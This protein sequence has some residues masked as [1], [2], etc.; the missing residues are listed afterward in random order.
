MQSKPLPVNLASIEFLQKLDA[1]E[2]GVWGTPCAVTL[3]DGRAFEICLAWENKR[4]SDKGDWLNPELVC[5]IR[6]I[7][8]RMPAKFAK[9]LHKAGESGM[10]YHIYVVELTDGTSFVHIAGNLMIDFLNLPGGYSPADIVDVI[11]HA[12]RERSVTEGYRE[13]EVYQSLEFSRPL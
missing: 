1:V 12:G 8:S 7:D 13:V 5:E 9:R 4:Y 6:A 11:P 2:T 10:G 3:L